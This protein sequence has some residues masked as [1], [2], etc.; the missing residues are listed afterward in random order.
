MPCMPQHLEVASS[1]GGTQKALTGMTTKGRA[2]ARER[3]WSCRLG[4]ACLCWWSPRL[5]AELL[6]QCP[7]LPFLLL[8]QLLLVL[9]L[10]LGLPELMSQ[11]LGGGG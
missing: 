6:L 11:A 2:G 1:T 9:G 3:L 7:Q 5:P 10:L 8:Q 4:Q